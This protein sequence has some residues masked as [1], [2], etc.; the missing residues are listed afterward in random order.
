MNQK[1]DS[2][3]QPSTTRNKN[4]RVSK[5]PIT[6]IIKG[7][8]ADNLR[9][10]SKMTNIEAHELVTEYLIRDTLLEVRDPINSQAY[11]IAG[12]TIYDS[13]EEAKEIAQRLNQWFEKENRRP[14]SDPYCAAANKKGWVVIPKSETSLT[15]LISVGAEKIWPGNF[16]R[17][18]L[19]GD[20]KTVRR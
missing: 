11:D 1:N 3:V 20:S 18:A 9:F 6:L 5:E 16:C 14:K 10:L 19:S 13:K 17:Q 12:A 15:L 7:K 4:P 8:Q 2:K